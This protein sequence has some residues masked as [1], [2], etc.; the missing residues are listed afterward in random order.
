MFSQKEVVSSE[1]LKE[2]NEIFIFYQQ[3]VSG[4]LEYSRVTWNK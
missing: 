1:F 2:I 4:S 3:S